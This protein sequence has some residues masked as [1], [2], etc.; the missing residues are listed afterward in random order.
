MKVYE[1]VQDLYTEITAPHQDIKEVDAWVV[2]NVLSSNKIAPALGFAP[3]LV[4]LA[5]GFN[6]Q[7]KEVIIKSSNDSHI[8]DFKRQCE[9]RYL[10]QFSKRIGLFHPTKNKGTASYDTVDLFVKDWVTTPQG[11]DV[12]AYNLPVL[13]DHA[14]NLEYWTL[15]QKGGDV[16]G[17]Q[18]LIVTVFQFRTSTFH[19]LFVFGVDDA[20]RSRLELLYK[21]K[22]GL[23]PHLT[24]AS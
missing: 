21:S 11:K 24:N 19:D 10:D 6:R 5:D 3:T 15:S 9:Q 7:S 23:R 18:R 2:A 1:N 13:V 16:V 20:E 4:T 17:N 14:D 12:I 8:N 22:L